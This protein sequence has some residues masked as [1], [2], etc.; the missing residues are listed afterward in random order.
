[1]REAKFAILGYRV[2]GDVSIN[3]ARTTGIGLILMALAAG[4]A[5]GALYPRLVIAGNP[6]A[7]SA[8][9][10]ASPGMFI[11]EIALWIAILVLDVIVAV[12]LFRL[13][14]NTGR[15][16]MIWS[17]GFRLGYV[18]IMLPAVV[19]LMSMPCVDNSLVAAGRFQSIWSLGLIV[20][21]VHLF[22]LAFAVARSGF[23]PRI[24][25]W[26]LYIAGPS[27][28]LIHLLKLTG[29]GA[30]NL[31][32]VLEA[33]LGIPMTLAELGLAVWLLIAAGTTCRRN[34]MAS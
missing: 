23:V 31:A 21:G 1:M 20:F 26:L 8:A 33:V 6:A 25:A 29:I 27:Y 32:G 12:S 11:A 22:L 4:V 7:T 28:S 15:K 34:K 17:T 30:E 3:P 2:S 19:S 18:L 5:Y 24:F 13:F 10:N 14:E 16:L 9:L